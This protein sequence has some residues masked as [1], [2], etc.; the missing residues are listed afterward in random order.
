MFD[1]Q[2]S[3]LIFFFENEVGSSWIEVELCLLKICY[4]RAFKFCVCGH[5]P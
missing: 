1:A 5:G 3:T 2:G 4:Q